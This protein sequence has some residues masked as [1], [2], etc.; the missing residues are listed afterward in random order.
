MEDNWKNQ[1]GA[2]T[3]TMS[4]PL[5]TL[6]PFGRE[7]VNIVNSQYNIEVNKVKVQKV[8]EHLQVQVQTLV[9]DLKRIKTQ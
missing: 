9:N 4:M 6:F 8:N 2:F 5:N 1:R 7:Q 3:L